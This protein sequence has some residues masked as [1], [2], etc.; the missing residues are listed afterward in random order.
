MKS[1][2][3][4]RL[5]REFWNATYMLKI[6]HVALSRYQDVFNE[7]FTEETY[8]QAKRH[9]ELAQAFIVTLKSF[10]LVGHEKKCVDL[11]L[12]AVQE[13][14]SECQKIFNPTNEIDFNDGF[15]F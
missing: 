15:L 9:L 3:F 4:N 14:M 13:A 6:H 7:T 5:R 8:L 1:V 10:Y 2:S 11:L 12:L